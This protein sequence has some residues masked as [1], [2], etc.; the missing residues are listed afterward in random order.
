MKL[1]FLVLLAFSA[2]LSTV[3]A[4]QVWVDGVS[5]EQGWI[6][7]EKAPKGG[8]GDDLLCWA[9]SASNIIDYWQQRYIV[10]V[11][12]PTGGAIWETFKSSCVMD[13]GG[14]FI[15][16][17]QWW[18]GGDYEG[19]T[20]DNDDKTDLS[21]YLDN[22]AVYRQPTDEDSAIRTDLNSFDGY[23]W[24]SFS[25]E[26]EGT[27]FVDGK[28]AHLLN[29]LHGFDSYS[30]IENKMIA[31]LSAPMSLSI[32]DTNGKLAH[33]ITLWGMD[34]TE[35]DTGNVSV[36]SIWITDSDD[37]RHQLRQIS[38][39]YQEEDGSTIYLDGYSNNPIYGDI[40]LTEAFGINTAESDTWNLAR[41]VPEP[42]TATLSLLGLLGLLARRRRT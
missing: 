38:T 13:T 42:T 23:Y 17:M 6:D 21:T 1:S 4:A 5:A 41:A 10:P 3:A 25:Y 9:A 16:A 29:F 27:M 8:D 37:Y 30:S 24:D 20:L 36:N 12:T 2:T 33:A 32:R 26:Y 18:L 39:Y 34:Y 35:D 40:Y 31:E 15:S 22:R 28:Q 11:N 7:Y 19:I 14:R